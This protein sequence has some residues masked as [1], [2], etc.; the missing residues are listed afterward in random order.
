[1][2]EKKN[3]LIRTF[4]LGNGRYRIPIELAVAKNG[5]LTEEE[6][7]ANKINITRAEQYDKDSFIANVKYGWRIFKAIIIHGDETLF[8]LLIKEEDH[9]QKKYTSEGRCI[10]PNG[11]GGIK[12]CPLRLPNPYY[13]PKQPPAKNNPKTIKNS[14]DG[15]PFN[16]FDK[17]SFRNL[18]LEGMTT[19]D[20]YGNLSKYEIETSIEPDSD[21]FLA[22]REEILKF[23]ATKYPEKLQIFTLLLDGLNRNEVAEELGI[24]TSTLYKMGK[25]LEKDLLQLLEKLW[26]LDINL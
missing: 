14:C 23:I 25:S 15:C 2:I 18:N 16:T 1:M 3:K 7:L 17:P 24:N 12:R 4:N 10:V 20:A 9:I 22:A 19:V 26:Y 5:K 13:N 21:K 11:R 8:K 6:I